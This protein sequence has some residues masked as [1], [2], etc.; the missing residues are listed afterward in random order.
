MNSLT[1][2]GRERVELE[3]LLRVVE[4]RERVLVKKRAVPNA[5]G[6]LMRRAAPLVHA[7]IGLVIAWGVALM[8]IV[9][10]F[11]VANV[12]LHVGA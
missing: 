10:T 4:T 2:T 1:L 3:E 6:L 5:Q 8:G 7:A 12:I 11:A 9:L